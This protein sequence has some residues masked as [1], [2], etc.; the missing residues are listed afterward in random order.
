MIKMIHNRRA[1]NILDT[2]ELISGRLA[3]G[4]D[5]SGPAWVALTSRD[6]RC[7]NHANNKHNTIEPCETP[8]LLPTNLKTT[9]QSSNVIKLE[10]LLCDGEFFD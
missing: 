3:P 1:A 6:F 10:E 2:D 8:M 4:T 5:N 7:L 9:K